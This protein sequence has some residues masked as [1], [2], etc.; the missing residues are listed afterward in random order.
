MSRLGVAETRPVLSRRFVVAHKRRRLIDAIVE[1]SDEQGYE[2]TTVGEIVKR[3]RFARQTF[4]GNFSNREELLLAAV[5]VTLAEAAHRVEDACEA[6]GPAW[7]DRMTA[8]LG[9]FLAFADERRDAV[10]MCMVDARAV[11]AGLARYD[12]AIQHYAGLLRAC[13]PAYASPPGT[14]EELLI[15]GIASMVRRRLRLG[16]DER[17]IDLMPQLSEFVLTLYRF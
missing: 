2:A 1:L 13:V 8:G 6:A 11:P 3:A 9:A 12:A 16:L 10:R 17:L 5:D 14:T 7:E 4:Y 15:G